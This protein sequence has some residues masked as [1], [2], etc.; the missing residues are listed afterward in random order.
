[1]WNLIKSW[2]AME[3]RTSNID[4]VNGKYISARGE[5]I[6][7]IDGFVEAVPNAVTKKYIEYT[8]ELLTTFE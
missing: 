2:A 6:T 3:V 7:C 8:E 1:M 4:Y 5:T